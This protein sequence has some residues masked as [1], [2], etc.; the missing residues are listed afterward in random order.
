MLLP[1]IEGTPGLRPRRPSAQ[2]FSATSRSWSRRHVPS[3]TRTPRESFPMR[4][5][6]QGGRP[7]RNHRTPVQCSAEHRINELEPVGCMRTTHYVHR[8]VCAVP[9]RSRVRRAWR[10]ASNTHN[11]H[12]IGYLMLAHATT[13]NDHARF[14]RSP[15]QFIE[16]ADIAYNVHYQAWVLERVEVDHISQ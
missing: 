7:N 2:L 10:R 4:Q 15:R 1:L 3:R 5:L 6:H 14:L 13:K 8:E 9:L 11:E 12:S 16:S